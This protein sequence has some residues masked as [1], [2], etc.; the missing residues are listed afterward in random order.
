MIIIVN[1]MTETQ[2]TDRFYVK[3]YNCKKPFSIYDQ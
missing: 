1:I 3:F 2:K